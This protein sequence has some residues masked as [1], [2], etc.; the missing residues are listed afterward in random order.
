MT[1]RRI[2]GLL[3]L[4]ASL[5]LANGCSEMSCTE[6]A[7]ADSLTIDLSEPIDVKQSVTLELDVEGTFESCEVSSFSTRCGA[8]ELS[9]QDGKLT[10]LS[11]WGS[12]DEVRVHVFRADENVVDHT[13]SNIEY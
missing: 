8:A 11:F 7:C 9:I 13:F 6:A 5:G 1:R 12:P 4:L 2:F 3:C 10:S